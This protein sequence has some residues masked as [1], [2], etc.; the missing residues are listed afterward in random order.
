MLEK[1]CKQIASPRAS[2]AH[3][4][5]P[6]KKQFKSQ[7]ILLLSLLRTEFIMRARFLG[8]PLP[9]RVNM[10]MRLFMIHFQK[11]FT[12]NTAQQCRNCVESLF[13]WLTE[14]QPQQTC[15]LMSGPINMISFRQKHLNMYPE[16][17]S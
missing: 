14:E 13:C 9:G 17:P 16:K 5:N 6:R 8:Q 4:S 10:L 2:S 1:N 7:P 3:C 12:K 15:L 11:C